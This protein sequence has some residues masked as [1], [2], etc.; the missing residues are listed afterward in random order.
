MNLGQFLTLATTEHVLGFSELQII[1]KVEVIDC[2]WHLVCL[3]RS[4]NPN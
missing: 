2:F 1:F 4:F 3:A